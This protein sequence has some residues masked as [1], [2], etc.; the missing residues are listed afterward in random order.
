MPTTTTIFKCAWHHFNHIMNVINF[1]PCFFS[2]KTILLHTWPEFPWTRQGLG[3]VVIQGGGGGGGGKMTLVHDIRVSFWCRTS[4]LASSCQILTSFSAIHF[5]VNVINRN[6]TDHVFTCNKDIS[7]LCWY[8]NAYG[9]LN[10]IF[11]E[12]DSIIG[13][14]C[15]FKIL[16]LWKFCQS[17][18]C[19]ASRGLL[20]D[21]IFNPHLY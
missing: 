5:Y 18:N 9:R 10:T 21:G 3:N 13:L 19:S 2:L 1:N 17:S 16:S 14:R 4:V 6:W 7:A 20:S 12:K 15:E 8:N 11:E